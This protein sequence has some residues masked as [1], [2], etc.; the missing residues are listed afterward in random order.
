[1][2]HEY[3]LD[4]GILDLHFS[5]FSAGL[6]ATAN[7][8]GCLTFGDSRA[9]ETT[10]MIDAF[11]LFEFPGSLKDS[12]VLA[13]QWHPTSET[14]IG[15]TL[16]TGEVVLVRL[17]GSF[18]AAEINAIAGGT[19]QKPVP[20]SADIS[21]LMKHD[22][23]AWTM[24]FTPSGK[25]LLSGGDDCVLQ[26]AI[27]RK[28][29]DLTDA[30]LDGYDAEWSNRKIHG[31]G[32]TSILPL[33]EN[34]YLTGSYDDHIRLIEDKAKLLTEQNLGGGVWRLKRI[35]ESIHERRDGHF[36][37]LASCMHAGVRILEISRDDSSIWGINVIASFS[38]HKSM[39]YG[40]D[41]RLARASGAKAIKVV[42]T[43]FYD[44]LVCVWQFEFR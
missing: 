11:G 18:S 17:S 8:T 7:S 1:M 29:D 36:Y 13:F 12:L 14:T 31:A 40:S 26:F 22:L 43:S 32:V 5:P 44:R 20:V 35:A 10:A 33:G 23:E 9:S 30:G 25:A 16:S 15:A 39:N 21:F 24:A 3:P 42:S 41:W 4:Y 27:S 28:C 2:V 38:E 6:L 19:S 37:V 34:L